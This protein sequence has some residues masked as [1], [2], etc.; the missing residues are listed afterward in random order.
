MGGRQGQTRGEME[1]AMKT[2]VVTG[3]TTFAVTALLFAATASAG[4]LV[5]FED[6]EAGASVQGPGTVHPYVQ[7]T[8]INAN[9]AHT[10]AG[11][12]LV[13]ETGVTWS[14]G[15]ECW[16][17][18][19]PNNPQ[20]FQQ[21][22]WNNCLDDRNGTRVNT[23][24]LTAFGPC[25]CPTPQPDKKAKG[26]TDWGA[27]CAQEPQEFEFTFG[28]RTVAKFGLRMFDFGDFNCERREFMQVDFRAYDGSGEV[29][30]DL[31]PRPCTCDI[32]PPCTW[33]C[34]DACGAKPNPEESDTET[35][36]RRL[37]VA[38]I[39]IASVKL[40]VP[41]TAE[42]EGKTYDPVGWDP[43]VAFD[44]IYAT[45]EVPID[46]KPRS[47][48]NPI[49][50]GRRGVLP[51][52]I[53]GTDLIPATE[54]N[55]ETVRLEGVAPLRWSIKDVATPYEPY[56]GRGVVNGSDQL[57]E[58]DCTTLGPDG[59]DDLVLHFDTPSLPLGPVEGREVRTLELTGELYDGTPF[60]GEDVVRLMGAKSSQKA[61]G[62]GK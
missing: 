48:P 3:F 36:Y 18:A 6:M 33:C 47:C 4:V 46:I 40:T 11:N 50:V 42:Y 34:G 62:K 24:P 54:V 35:G 22:Q 1:A 20:P 49:N 39:G 29:A 17:Y 13:V 16:A 12:A 37:E 60:V 19:A 59:Y 7:I 5:H 10:A 56:R 45:F 27:R 30:A 15:S 8:P 55:P 51:V 52:A 44:S 32:N 53:L 41:E 58:K 31:V 2:R 9:E 14:H 43:H 38:G 26:F 21:W 61:K 57:D 25:P 28:G 23:D